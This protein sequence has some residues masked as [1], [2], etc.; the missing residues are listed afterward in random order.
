MIR[1]SSFSVVARV[2]L[3]FVLLLCVIQSWRPLGGGFDFWAHAAVGRWIANHSRIPTENLFLWTA[4]GFP[5]VYHSWLSQ[6]LF[7]HIIDKTGPIGVMVFTTLVVCAVYGLLWKLWQRRATGPMPS[8]APLVFLAAIW[9]S[10]PRFQPRQ[11]LI[12]ALFLVFFLSF[13]LDWNERRLW[14]ERNGLRPSLWNRKTFWI[15]ALVPLWINLHALVV[16]A[17]VLL[18]VAAVC[19]AVQ[20]KMDKRARALL[21]ITALCS[22]AML[23][24]PWGWNYWEA[25]G[26][27]Q[28]GGQATYIEEWWPV[29]TRWPGMANAVA[30]EAVLFAVAL[31]SWIRN[32]SRR[33]A[34]LFWLLLMG[35]MF[36]RS[37]RMLW[38][39][40]IVCLVVMASNA[41]SFDANAIWS[42]WRT[43]SKQEAQDEMPLGLRHIARAG[44]FVVML[45]SIVSFAQVVPQ[46]LREFWPVRGVSVK[47]PTRAADYILKRRA[48]GR[49]FADYEYAS[50]LQWRFNGADRRNYVPTRG[51]RPLYV[52]LLNAYPDAVLKE[53]FTILE[54]RPGGLRALDSRAIN[55]VVLGQ[56][57]FKDAIVGHLDKSPAWKRVLGDSTARVWIRRKIIKPRPQRK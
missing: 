30:I 19:D 48:P 27:L 8:V 4:E 39:L 56:P 5:W 20:Y 29:W 37:R 7:F 26:Q 44:V 42:R 11:E 38:M 1:S 54:A 2:G 3:A 34:E 17:V 13:L 53:Y 24:N 25:T 51:L 18:F 43:L 36:L 49:I 57:H 52:D 47:A 40:A 10:T 55:T 16:L 14:D 9:V 21:W 46:N 35:A 32:P 31:W 28:R 33:W 15:I 22:A 41:R 45:L 23:I 12:T 6:W 50:Y